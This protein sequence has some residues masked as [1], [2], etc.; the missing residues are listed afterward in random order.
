MP[1]AHVAVDSEHPI[2]LVGSTRS[3]TTLLSLMLRQHP[4]IAYAGELEWVWDFPFKGEPVLETVPPDGYH[5]WLRTQRHFQHHHLEADSSLTFR[6]LV[7]SLVWQMRADADPGG[8]KTWVAWTMHRHLPQVLR[9][10]PNARLIHLVRDGRDV[11]ASWIRHGWIGSGYEAAPGWVDELVTWRAVASGVDSRQRMEMRFE[12]LVTDP[13]RELRRLC[14]FIGEHY[15]DEMLRY[16][17]RSTYG[18]VD[19]DQAGKWASQLGVHDLR[20]F[21]ALAGEEL[22][23]QGYALSGK[24]S[25]PMHPVIDPWLTLEAKLRRHRANART[26]GLGLHLAN[27]LANRVGPQWFKERIRNELNSI[28]EANLK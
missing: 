11:C 2:F 10:W 18:P 4:R 5:D 26:F 9:I 6:E 7:E 17:E 16:P 28:T 1:G 21:E 20:L 13:V 23:R 25:F 22:V 15:E 14:T 27:V 8:Q 19:P 12:H 24:P 3:G